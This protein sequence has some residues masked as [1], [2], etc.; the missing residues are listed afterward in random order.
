MAS[1]KPMSVEQ[2]RAVLNKEAPPAASATIHP[3]VQGA[4]QDA[5]DEQ[6]GTLKKKLDVLKAGRKMTPSQ[7]REGLDLLFQKYDF[8]PVEELVIMAMGTDDDRFKA[9]ICEFLIEFTIPKLKSIEVSGHV[10]HSHK[11]FIRRFDSNGQVTDK[12]LPQRSLSPGG[13]TL[14]GGRVIDV[15]V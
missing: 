11:V 2:M 6:L 1:S 9:H 5:V 14:S 7:I 12:E 10:E 3:A 4:I 15:E 13:P 8:S